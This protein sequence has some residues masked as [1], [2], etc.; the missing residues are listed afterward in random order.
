ML[1]P[2]ANQHVFKKIKF[3]LLKYIYYQFKA[4]TKQILV[5]FSNKTEN[6]NLAKNLQQCESPILI[7]IILNENT[8]SLI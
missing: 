6:F 1:Q 4:P 5:F 8:I 2:V 3:T 7:L